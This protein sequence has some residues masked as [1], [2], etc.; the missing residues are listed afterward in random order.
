MRTIAI[1]P[2]LAAMCVLG[3]LGFARGCHR[4]RRRN[5]DGSPVGRRPSRRNGRV[6]AAVLLHLRRQ[7]VGRAVAQLE[8]DAG[9]RELDDRRIEHTLTWTDPES[10]LVVRCVAIEYRDFPAV[11]WT[12]YFRNTGT[13]D[14]P[15]LENIQA[16]DIDLAAGRRWRVPAAPRRRLAGQRLRLRPAGNAAGAASVQANRRGGRAA[17]QHRTVATST[18]SGAPRA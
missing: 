13:A 2:T 7:A 10:G 17:D 18:C 11:E 5:G 14:T 8:A 15:I 12:L 6:R 1:L 4:D 3:P 16:L 9:T